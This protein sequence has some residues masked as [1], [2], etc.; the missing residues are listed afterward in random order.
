MERPLGF[1]LR[2]IR[3]LKPDRV[4][5]LSSRTWESEREVRLSDS[6]RSF[7]KTERAYSPLYLGRQVFSHLRF[8][9]SLGV[10]VLAQHRNSLRRWMSRG[11]RR[12]L[13]RRS[14]GP[15]GA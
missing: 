7:H 15:F 9:R 2:R 11:R 1:V 12:A 14:L 6:F 3:V 8:K 5:A 4:F 13:V 10:R